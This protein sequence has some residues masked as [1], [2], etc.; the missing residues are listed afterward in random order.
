MPRQAALKRG[1][2]LRGEMGACFAV[3]SFSSGWHGGR[4]LELTEN[5]VMKCIAK[6]AKWYENK[7]V[8]ISGSC[9]VKNHH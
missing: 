3:A 4:H 1:R 7:R 5:Q 9:D 6:I 2:A 8:R